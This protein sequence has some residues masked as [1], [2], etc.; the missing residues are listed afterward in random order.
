MNLR[1]FLCSEMLILDDIPTDAGCGHS[2]GVGQGRQTG[3][4]EEEV[5]AKA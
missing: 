5:A 4:T 3:G 2:G 1:P